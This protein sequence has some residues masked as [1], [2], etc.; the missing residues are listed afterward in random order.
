MTDVKD[1]APSADPAEQARIEE[2]VEHFDH[3]D[4]RMAGDPRPVYGMMARE[5]PVKWSDKHGGYWVI[6]GF[7]EAH[8]AMHHYEQFNRY[9]AAAVPAYPRERVML[10]I[11]VDPPVHSKYRGLLAPVFAPS[12]VAALESHIRTNAAELID[13]FAD[14]GHCEL[15]SELADPLPTVIFTEM[16]GLPGEEAPKFKDWKNAIVHGVHDDPTGTGGRAQAVKLVEAYLA[17]MLEDRKR[18]R[19]DDI[20]SVLLDSRVDGERLTDQELIDIAYLLFLAGLDTVTASIGLHFLHLAQHPEHRDQLVQHP[21]LIPQAVEE[22]LRYESLVIGGYTIAEDF[23]F[24]GCPMKKGRARRRQHRGRRSGPTRVPGSGHCDLRPHTQPPPRIR[25][26]SAPVRRFTPGS[27]RAQSRARRDASAGPQLPA[28]ARR[29]SH[30]AREQRA[31]HRPPPP[32]LGGLRPTVTARSAEGS[33]RALDLQRHVPI[34]CSSTRLP[35]GSSMN[36]CWRS[37]RPACQ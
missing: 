36:T 20:I 2:F 21:D 1:A 6:S 30:P 13:A 10:P 3:Q 12:R 34:W 14:R 4:P 5:C 15:I 23:E 25:R 8:Y 29:R 35:L 28:R 22:L 19:R 17:D 27:P 16:L 32:G 31:R 33:G 18:E 37:C 7:E 9:P 26:R 24:H 11:E